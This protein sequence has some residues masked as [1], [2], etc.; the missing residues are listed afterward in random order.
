MSDGMEYKEHSITSVIFLPPP[1]KKITGILSGGKNQTAP[2]GRTKILQSVSHE[3]Q[4]KLKSCS[5]LKMI[6]EIMAT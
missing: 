6:K 4:V 1:K 2:N 3:S 5:K